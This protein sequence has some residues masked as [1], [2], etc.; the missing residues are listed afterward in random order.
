ML[1]LM[2][3]KLKLNKQNL[4]GV[5]LRIGLALVFL[6]AALDSLK[7]PLIWTG[8]LPGFM[9]SVFKPVMA[10][11]IL[12]VYELLLAAW[13]LSGKYKKYAALVCSLTLAGIIAA[14]TKQLIITFRDI[15]LLFAALALFF[16]ED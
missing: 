5:L 14:N 3:V 13:L 4:P 12:A 1:C 15:G 10:V 9:T 8:Y 11:R 6:Y 16:L 2:T 7:E